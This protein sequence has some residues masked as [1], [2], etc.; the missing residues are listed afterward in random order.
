MNSSVIFG[1]R[2]QTI[3]YFHRSFRY[4]TSPNNNGLVRSKPLPL[5][6]SNFLPPRTPYLRCPKVLSTPIRQAPP[7]RMG[8]HSLSTFGLVSLRNPL[9]FASSPPFSL[10]PTLHQSQSSPSHVPLSPPLFPPHLHLPT[11][12]LPQYHSTEYQNHKCCLGE[13]GPSC[14]YASS[15]EYLLAD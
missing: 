9:H 3:S 12:R 10:R 6:S 5:Q 1:S 11:P 14:I 13:Y 2:I 4:V 15:T 8:F 7:S